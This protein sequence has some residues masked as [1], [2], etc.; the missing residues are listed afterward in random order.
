MS[1]DYAINVFINCPFDSG[2][3]ELRNALV[4]TIF[5]CGF[6][7]KCALEENDSGDVRVSKIKRLIEESKFGIHDLSRISLDDV[8][9]LPRFNMPFE[10]GIFTG[11]KLFGRGQQKQKVCLILD[12][13]KYRYQKYISDVAGCDIKSHSDKQNEI[14]K[15]VR[16]WLSSTIKTVKIPGGKKIAERYQE[17]S[18][19]LPEMCEE[20]SY[21]LDDLTFN[22]YCQLIAEWLKK[23]K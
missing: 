10:L 1:A 14:I 7:P 9:N 11:A 4:F 21:D 19:A 15:C 2:Y 12:S 13:D 16:D 17:F 23:H 6:R 22:D 18:N 8:N 5:D 3:L 20:V